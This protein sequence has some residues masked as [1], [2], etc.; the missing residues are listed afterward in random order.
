MIQGLEVIKLLNSENI[1]DV[2]SATEMFKN[3][4]NDISTSSFNYTES[5]NGSEHCKN[6]EFKELNDKIKDLEENMRK[7]PAIIDAV[8]SGYVLHGYDK[9][10][11]TIKNVTSL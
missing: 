8:R 6:E 10:V 11:E 3:L 7:N 9:L 5:I 1:E 2:I 4:K